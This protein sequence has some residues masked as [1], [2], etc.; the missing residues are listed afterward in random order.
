MT[1]ELQEQIDPP[2]SLW[3]DRSFAMF[4]AAQMTS[5]AGSA[6]SRV[7]LPVLMYDR[8]GS[9]GLTA[10]VW[11][12]QA[13]PYLILGLPAGALADRV[14]RRRLM[15]VCELTSALIVASIPFAAATASVATGQLLAVSLLLAV[16]FVWFDS[17]NF[18]A[19][20]AIAGDER[21]VEATSAYSAGTT[22]V[23]I[24]GPALG[25]VLVGVI[26]PVHAL[27]VDAVS[28]VLGALLLLAVRRPFQV[29][30]EQL[31]RLGD[32]W[33]KMGRDI[34]EG[35]RY[36]WDQRIVRFM[37]LVTSAM[38]VSG[39]AVFGLTVV[40][41]IKVLGMSK[42]DSRIGLLFA[43]GEAGTLVASIAVGRLFRKIR[44][45][46]LVI[47]GL[48]VN[49]LCLIGLV[50]AHGIISALI[51]MAAFQFSYTVVTITGVSIRQLLT[52][53]RLRSRVNSVARMVAWG[54]NPVGAIIA[55]LLAS[56][57][58]IRLVFLLM[59][60]GVALA[61]AGAVLSPIRSAST[62]RKPD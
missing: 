28:Y 30:E 61:S 24:G 15:V 34:R 58:S 43:V 17:A 45:G 25:G 9:A 31:E 3:T 23:N 11:A 10:L 57:I 27:V 37:T 21:V 14:N 8:T 52:P 56:G 35:V 22:V 49:A 33:R 1:T 60:I 26:G 19:L 42:T 12:L 40:Y 51:W 55:G 20:A 38:A 46:R 4:M 32:I 2:R 53:D 18:G 62:I 41:G 59:G 5:L 7:A 36:V 29:H 48:S 50:L 44:T 6:V 13:V 47:L 16:V 39:G 54:G